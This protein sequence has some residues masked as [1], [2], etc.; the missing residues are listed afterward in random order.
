[1]TYAA[2]TDNSRRLGTIAGV[3]AIHGL[4]G[5]VFISG[6]A[7]S[8]M[9]KV[10]DPFTVRNIPIETPPPLSVPKPP[11][12]DKVLPQQPTVAP[13]T[14]IVMPTMPTDVGS[15][16]VVV[17]LPPLTGT[18]G[19][20]TVTVDPPVLPRAASQAAGVA[21][22][23]NRN[24]WISTDDYPPSALRAGEQGV[25]G[26]A[27]RIAADGR[28]DSCTVTESSGHATLDQA[29]CRLYQRR[30]RFTPARDDGGTPIIGTFNDR[31]RWQLPM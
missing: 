30:A 1:M 3:A 2:H 26:I 29:T 10:T 21:A 5:Y 22:R 15:P 12:L 16:V 25:V 23:G 7:A 19:P 20:G 14:P 17:P 6:M 28:I 27:L 31:V 11:T 18:F 9:E 24:D 13:P 8:F 4:L